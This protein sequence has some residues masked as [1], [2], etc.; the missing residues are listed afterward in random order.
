M[1]SSKFM[2]DDDFAREYRDYKLDDLINNI[3]LWADRSYTTNMQY[4]M[5]GV[6][7]KRAPFYSLS[8]LHM[9]P[10]MDDD[11]YNLYADGLTVSRTPGININTMQQT[12][13]SGIVP[14]MTADEVSEFF[15]YRDDTTTDNTF[16]KVS[17]FWDY[18]TKNVSA[19]RGDQKQVQQV[20][21]DLQQKGINLVVDET[22]FKITVQATVN[23]AVK[24]FEVWVSLTGVGSG[25]PNP[26]SSANP[27]PTPS[28]PPLSGPGGTPA[29]QQTP[30]PDTGLRINF[31]RVL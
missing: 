5:D 15:K 17:D 19:F 9:I 6:Q 26:S 28:T 16:K 12:T 24:T 27:S 23:Q 13:L 7:P 14:Q 31:V 2:T 11:L 20:Q 8:E 10:T 29:G 30:V 3:A 1:M 18:I 25:S 4:P 22:E 21:Q